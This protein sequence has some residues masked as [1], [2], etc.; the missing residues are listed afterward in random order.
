MLLRRTILALLFLAAKVLPTEVDMNHFAETYNH[1]AEF[2]ARESTQY[3][4]HAK[5]PS[6]W[7]AVKRAWKVFSNEMDRFYGLRR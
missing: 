6:L 2:R 4:F 1:W 7:L 3:S 5:E